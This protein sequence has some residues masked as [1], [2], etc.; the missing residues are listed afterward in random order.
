MYEREENRKEGGERGRGE[1]QRRTATNPF[2]DRSSIPKL[3]RAT[4]PRGSRT[5]RR[6]ASSRK[7]ETPFLRVAHAS[8][9]ET[10][11]VTD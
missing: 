1:A 4:K 11:G 8:N 2:F 6:V 10:K 5:V 3:A 7:A 9:K